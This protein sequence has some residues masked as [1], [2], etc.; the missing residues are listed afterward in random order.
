MGSGGERGRPALTISAYGVHGPERASK[1]AVDACLIVYL[2]L[3]RPGLVNLI[4]IRRLW[5]RRCEQ[6]TTGKH[7]HAESVLK[8]ANG[9]MHNEDQC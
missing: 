3:A 4:K 7:I 5:L 1:A 8:E 9:T 6:M 2:V